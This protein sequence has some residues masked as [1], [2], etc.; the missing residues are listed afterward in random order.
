MARGRRSSQVIED[1][2]AEIDQFEQW[3]QE[4]AA[5]PVR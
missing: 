2:K 5:A 4:W 3:Q 1:Q